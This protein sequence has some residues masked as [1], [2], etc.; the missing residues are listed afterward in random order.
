MFSYIFEN[1][2]TVAS[3]LLRQLTIIGIALPI[4]VA[5]GVPIG[6]LVSN[7]RRLARVVVAVAG[8]LMTIPSLALFGL[9]VIILAPFNAGIGI[10]P[11]V[12][13]I[14]I[15][16]LLP[17]IRNTLVA[18]QA[19]D[20]GMIKAA[21]GMGMT[22]G[23]ILARVRLPLAVPVIMAGLRNAAVLGVS[24]TTI[25]Y[26]VGAKGLGYFIFAGLSRTR[27]DMIL[28]G[29]VIVGILGIAT[30]YLLLFVEELITP[31]G[32]KTTRTQ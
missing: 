5:I 14:V 8:V 21:R 22:N 2:S 32:I 30:N 25:A 27:V 12:T 29:A 18:V 17:M 6:I 19:V 13:A 1:W 10:P 11:A 20:M 28:T 31:R 9:M 15:Y 26:L 4:A 16:S 3:Q 7:H 23:Q 24:V